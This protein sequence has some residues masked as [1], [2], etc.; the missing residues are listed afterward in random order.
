MTGSKLDDGMFSLSLSVN[1]VVN[2]SLENGLVGVVGI[3]SERSDKDVVVLIGVLTVD[4]GE[5]DGVTGRGGNMW[6]MKRP[7]CR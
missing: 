3:S 6:R 4:M 1:G 2:G 7:P 5:R